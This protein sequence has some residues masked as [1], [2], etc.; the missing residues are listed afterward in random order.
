MKGNLGID[1]FR[2]VT[3]IKLELAPPLWAIVK[4]PS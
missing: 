1:G 2:K 4:D 3:A